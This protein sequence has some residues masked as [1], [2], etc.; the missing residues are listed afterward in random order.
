MNARSL[1]HITREFSDHPLAELR[2]LGSGLRDAVS[3]LAPSLVKYTTRGRYP[4][5]NRE[6]LKGLFAATTHEGNTLLH[7]GPVAILTAATPH[8]E[9][10]VLEALAFSLGMKFRQADANAI[11]R[12]VFAEMTVHDSVPREF[13]LATLTFEATISASCF[14]QLKRHRMMTLLPQPYALEDGVIVPP[15]VRE[16]GLESVFAETITLAHSTAREL[17]AA[18]PLMGPY[19]LTN[20]QRR[21]V[22]LHMNARELY[23]F[24]RLRC[25]RHAQW[26]IRELAVQI[27]SQARNEWP[28]ML[29]LACGKDQFAERYTDYFRE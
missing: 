19:L 23:H 25:D 29:A 24:A 9:A 7:T 1:E 12:A 4:R 28:G 3:G 10:R 21:R 8:G 20:A 17:I 26:E 22:V 27:V 6:T 13:E 18:Q 5:A 11:W 2:T 15:S 16:A 14:A